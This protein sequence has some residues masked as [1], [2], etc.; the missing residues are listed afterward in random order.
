MNPRR[1]RRSAGVPVFARVPGWI[2]GDGI[3]AK[4]SLKAR[5]LLP[6]LYLHA[7]HEERKLWP[8]AR[9]LAEESGLS[10][11]HIGLAKKELFGAGL[12]VYDWNVRGE[13]HTI[14]MAEGGAFRFQLSPESEKYMMSQVPVTRGLEGYDLLGRDVHPLGQ[15]GV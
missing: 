8:F 1:K 9:T 10:R 13:T 11:R 6:V 3:Y 15:E 7:N 4:L 2:I 5:V 14:W 12:L